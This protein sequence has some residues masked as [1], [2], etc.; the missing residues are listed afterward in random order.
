[1]DTKVDKTAIMQG[2]IKSTSP[3]VGRPKREQ[4]KRDVEY[5]ERDKFGPTK[6]YGNNAKTFLTLDYDA[7]TRDRALQIV[8]DKIAKC[9]R[10][11]DEEA[12]L[13]FQTIRDKRKRARNPSWWQRLVGGRKSSG[14]DEMKTVHRLLGKLRDLEKARDNMVWFDNCPPGLM[15]HFFC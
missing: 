6:L 7:E 15:R 8:V 4:R 14:S 2:I 12:V 11:I 5:R 3:H 10:K 1:M 13:A 9:R